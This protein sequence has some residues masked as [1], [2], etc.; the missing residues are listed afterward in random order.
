MGGIDISP[1]LSSQE[2]STNNNHNEC[3]HKKYNN[4]V[5]SREKPENWEKQKRKKQE[6]NTL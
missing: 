5:K 2:K 1:S 4:K 3:G 6:L